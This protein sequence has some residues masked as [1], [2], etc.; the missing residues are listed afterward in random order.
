LLWFDA[1]T[2]DLQKITNID[3]NYLGNPTKTWIIY[4][5][6]GFLY[7]SF[8]A[9][10]PSL[11]AL[12]VKFPIDYYTWS[13]SVIIKTCPSE[14]S[15]IENHWGKVPADTTW[16]NASAT[17][18]TTGAHTASPSTATYTVPSPSNESSPVIKQDVITVSYVKTIFVQN[19]VDPDF[20]CFKAEVLFDFLPC[21]V[22]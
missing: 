1:D 6:E 4:H 9:G 8:E 5:Y 19:D 15:S 20:K 12:V 10:S 14:D 11:S 13:D 16:A 3:V 7:L 22:S 17:T 2:I 18:F 21:S